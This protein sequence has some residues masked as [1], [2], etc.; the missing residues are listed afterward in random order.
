MTQLTDW[1]GWGWT[2]PLINYVATL[3]S[4][5]SFTES[6]FNNSRL[7]FLEDEFELHEIIKLKSTVL[8]AHQSLALVWPQQLSFLSPPLHSPVYKVSQ[9][10]QWATSEWPSEHRPCHF[11]SLDSSLS[12]FLCLLCIFICQI[13]A[14]GWAAFSVYIQFCFSYWS[15][16]KDTVIEYL[17][18]FSPL[19]P[20]SPS[21]FLSFFSLC[22]KQEECWHWGQNLLL[23]WSRT[24]LQPGLIFLPA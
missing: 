18:G 24:S 8:T 9:K 1:G 20:F 23:F 12:L 11:C 21:P 14:D 15:F 6:V 13:R 22:L 17:H 7:H 5:L 3:G 4:V 2:A 16:Y 19:L 10:G